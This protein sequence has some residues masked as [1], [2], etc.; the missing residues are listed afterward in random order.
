MKKWWKHS[1][2]N[3]LRGVLAASCA[4][5]VFAN[6]KCVAFAEVTGKVTAPSARV[7]QTPDANSEV[8]ASSSS[9]KTVT[10]LSQ[11]T[12][13]SG[14]VWY[15]VYVDTNSTGYIRSD[16]LE[17]DTSSGTI[18]TTQTATVS[19]VEAASQAPTASG[20][21]TMPETGM[22]AQYATIKVGAAIIRSSASKNSGKVASLPENTQVIVSGQTEGTD[23]TWYYI[24]FTDTSGAEKTGYVRSDLITLGD[25][26]PVEA[27]PEEQQPEEQQPEEQ[28]PEGDDSTSQTGYEAVY[29]L[30]EETGQYV[31]M[32]YD[33]TTRE[34]QNLEDVLA[35][36]HA[37]SQND[38]LDAAT[39]AKQRIVIIVLIVVII[40]LAVAVTIMIF[41]LRDAYYEAY[42]DDEDE[43]DEEEEEEEDRRR[44]R[45]RDEREDEPVGRKEGSRRERDERSG[46]REGIRREESEG[47]RRVREE[48]AGE[49]V[50]ARRR[51]DEGEA[52]PVRRKSSASRE[53][54]PASSRRRTSESDKRMPAREVSYEE[55]LEAP[56]K[57]A[58]KKKAKNF[59]VD[60]DDF[61]FEFLN[62]KNKDNE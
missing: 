37:Q 13:A 9:G 7:R 10:I 47:R 2:S 8:I 15:E 59:L 21:E 16:L 60:E 25:M 61:E 12:D 32:L 26:V 45:R 46:K 55:E 18:P 23:K 1:K 44:R 35:A 11:T 14:Y 27:P 51:R 62:M 36:A 4:A 17:V 56:V 54:R 19:Q 50:A 5:F 28:Q 41:K 24:T 34:K 52:E 53:E 58:P 33:W 31:W 29:E 22:D 57:T 40:I 3:V 38:E 39:V 30:N 42:E 49:R 43:E 48:D 20:A 6:L